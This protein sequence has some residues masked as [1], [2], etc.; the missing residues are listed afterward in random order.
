MYVTFCK[1]IYWGEYDYNGIEESDIVE[2]IA[3]GN[4]IEERLYFVGGEY[5]ED[6]RKPIEEK[7]FDELYDEGIIE[8]ASKYEHFEFINAEKIKSLSEYLKKEDENISERHGPHKLPDWISNKY[9]IENEYTTDVKEELEPLGIYKDPFQLIGNEVY[10]LN[11]IKNKIKIINDWLNWN[12]YATIRMFIEDDGYD[13]YKLPVKKT[14]YNYINEID[15]SS[16]FWNDEEEKIYGEL[17]AKFNQD[18]F[19]LYFYNFRK[20]L[21]LPE[22]EDFLNIN[23]DHIEE[24]NKCLEWLEEKNPLG[25]K[26]VIYEIYSLRYCIWNH[27]KNVLNWDKD[28]NLLNKL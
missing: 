16:S 3:E 24:I 22:K 5:N 2:Y 15:F 14:N 21:K 9:K 10:I 4:G 12:D 6:R 18:P 1:H 28:G 19:K 8:H 17:G 27:Y 7:M 26:R 11:E 25:F 20:N 13:D 23:K